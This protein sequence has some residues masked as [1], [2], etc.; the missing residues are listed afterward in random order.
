MSVQW[1]SRISSFIFFSDASG[2]AY[3]ACIYVAHTVK[4]KTT[5]TLIRAR[6]KICKKGE[7]TI[8]KLELAAAIVGVKL[9]ENVINAEPLFNN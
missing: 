1:I 3:G 5:L 4:D 2:A 7:T 9:Y 6:A 8:P